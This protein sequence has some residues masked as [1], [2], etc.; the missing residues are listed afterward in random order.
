MTV[1]TTNTYDI[2][3]G[4]GA[5]TTWPFTFK[6][7]SEDEIEV[8]VSIS[9]G[10]P[11][12][13][14]SSL[15]TVTLSDPG[16]SVEYPLS[17]P[18]L[19]SNDNLMVRRNT[20]LT[21]ALVLSNQTAVFRQA[22]EDALD[23]LTLQVQAG[24]DK[25]SRSLRMPPEEALSIYPTAVD[26][27]LP[28]KATRANKF[29]KFDAD[30]LPDVN[31]FAIDDGV[32]GDVTV[33]GGGATWSVTSIAGLTEAD[34]S[35]LGTTTAM[36]AD[37]L[38]VFA[39]T[40]SAQLAG[41][42]SDETG[43]GALVFAASPVLVTPDLGTPSNLVL[44]NATG[45]PEA[46][47]TAHQGAI[48]HG[49]IAGL[50]DD[51]HTQ[52]LLV[53]GSRA[54]TGALDMGAQNMV[55]LADVTFRTGA[56]GGTLRTGTSAADKFVLQAYDVDGAAYQ[57]V[58]ELDAGN[59]PILQLRAN[60]LEIDDETTPTKRVIW[61][62]SGATA[63]TATTLTF[64]QTANRVITFPD[65]TDTLVGLAATQTL[66]NKTITNLVLDGS[67]T[68]ETYAWTSTSGAVT[69]ELEPANGTKQRLTLTGNI[70]SLTD[71]LAEGEEIELAIDDGTAYT[72]TWPT[73][74]WENNAGTAPTL[75]TSGYTRV[76]IW[77]EN[78][79]LYGALLMDGT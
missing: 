59:D 46:Q 38:G 53:N 9:G 78:S 61:S 60:F 11:S 76:A 8:W 69:T 30:G 37:H 51:D 5:S 15:Y 10:V 14:S 72:I 23:R 12:Q 19:T 44:T 43:S 34:I 20:P 48:D 41:V 67:V 24:E 79:T 45:L 47:V 33:S 63:S 74:E 31:V 52:Y 16:G 42:I 25:F 29:F 58:L 22:V 17:G 65:V 36:V 21:Q 68:E 77:K 3:T 7:Q 71:N 18:A 54:M 35:D 26:F 13:I 73:I 64:V 40:T 2:A 70:T 28:E 75:A 50:T 1:S 57:T 4:N 27:T 62:V 32:Y 56:S 6:A 39:P 66:T 49:S 55:D